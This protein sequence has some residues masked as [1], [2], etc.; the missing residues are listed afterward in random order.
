MADIRIERKENP[1]IWPWIL[2]LLVAALAV[3]GIAELFDEGEEVLADEDIEEVDV[4]ADRGTEITENDNTYNL[5]DYNDEEIE[6]DWYD[7]SNDYETYT[8]TMTGEMGLD[9]E[10]SHN[11]LMKLANATSALVASH[12][13]TAD[14]N[15]R[16]K[17]DK[18]RMAANAITKDPYA[19]NHA[20][21]I[22]MA[23]M[24]ITDALSSVQAAK[25]PGYEGA[26][27]EVRNS[28]QDI[29]K[30]T[31]T[32]NQKEDVRDFFGKARVAVKGM[33]DYDIKNR[34]LTA[35]SGAF[36]SDVDG[37]NTDPDNIDRED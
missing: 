36:Y 33:R 4:V 13:M 26:I 19:T 12:G 17:M 25:Y 1:T 3:W 21:M 22:K 2:G 20:D 15:M 28:A 37:M 29:S 16:A 34:D 18:I 8:T 14:V 23:A 7:L 11:A 30:A 32:L 31:L 9:H 24:N 10:F 5:I 27:S 6:N 35:E